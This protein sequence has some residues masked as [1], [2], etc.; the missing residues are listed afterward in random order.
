MFQLIFQVFNHFI[1]GLIFGLDF[2]DFLLMQLQL[3]LKDL[4]LH[5]ELVFFLGDFLE[6]FHVFLEECVVLVDGYAGA[7]LF[8]ICGL[9]V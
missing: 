8:A 6:V 4:V 2:L 5:L 3:F 9:F 1:N 7:S